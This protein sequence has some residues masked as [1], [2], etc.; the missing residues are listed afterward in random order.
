[1]LES[2]TSPWRRPWSGAGASLPVNAAT[3]HRYRGINLLALECSRLR[4]G[5]TDMR[6]CT[7]KQANSLGGRVRKG[8]KGTTVV[9]VKRET[10]ER[11]GET[12]CYTIGRAFT[13]FNAEQLDG[14]ALRPAD[15][16]EFTPVE[17]AQRIVEGYAG[18][19]VIEHGHHLAAYV[20]SLDLVAM[21]PRDCFESSERYYEVLFHELVHSTGHRSR[22]ARDLDGL[23]GDHS[24]SHEELVAEL[25]AAFLCGHAGI[26]TDEVLGQCAAYLRGWASRLRDR[27]GSLARAS[28]QA[29]RA[30]DVILG[31]PH[32]TAEAA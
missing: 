17:S 18:G 21:P 11:D 6:W 5:F 9:L 23:S 19:P 2:G 3:G 24:Y 15:T 28:S 14:A 13:V 10:V 7:L 12:K 1:M 29:Q 26:A 22:L 27:P 31:A 20:P 16:R 4:F 30:L 32:V 8:E 25:G